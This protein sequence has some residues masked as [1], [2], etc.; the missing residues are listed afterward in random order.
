MKLQ[1][2]DYPT[3]FESLRA[4]R[5]IAA[6]DARSDPRTFELDEGYLQP[7]GIQSLLD[8]AIRVRGKMVGVVC[9][10]QKGETR[11]WHQDEITYGGEIADQI[12]Q[13]ILNLERRN[14]EEAIKESENRYRNIFEQADDAIFL[15]D[16][17][18]FIDCNQR[19]EIVFGA[20]RTEIIGKNPFDFSPPLQPNGRKSAEVGAEYIR[21]AY[22]GEL[23]MFE[24]VHIHK[25]GTLF[26]AEVSLQS[27]PS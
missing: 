15:M 23:Q 12:A 2:R 14:A 27:W 4:G 3:Y 5:A 16:G 25:D 13:V 10:E 22:S 19:T 9:F 11:Y 1:A 24:W 7:L 8:S 6:Q 17:D 26:D 21:T 18:R 20:T